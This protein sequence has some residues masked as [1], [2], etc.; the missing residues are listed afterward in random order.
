MIN[1]PSNDKQSSAVSRETEPHS[2]ATNNKFKPNWWETHEHVSSWKE[3]GRRGLIVQVVVVW[4]QTPT[5]TTTQ[6]QIQS[7]HGKR[8]RRIH[9]QN[10]NTATGGSTGFYWGVKRAIC[11]SCAVTWIFGSLVFLYQWRLQIAARQKWSSLSEGDVWH[12][13]GVS[14]GANLRELSCHPYLYTFIM[15]QMQSAQWNAVTP[16]LFSLL[17]SHSCALLFPSAVKLL[18]WCLSRPAARCHFSLN[19]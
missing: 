9:E 1:I 8:S 5:L 13:V 16:S 7:E 10:T 18:H 12:C 4:S 3:F 17:P 14:R 11:Q 15:T 19:E 6:T 2:M